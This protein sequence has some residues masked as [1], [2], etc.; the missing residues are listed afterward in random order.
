MDKMALDIKSYLREKAGLV[1]AFL[2]AYLEKPFEPPVLGESMRYSLLAGGKRLRPILAMASYEACG[3]NPEEITGCASSIE[4]IHT[5]SLIHDD[6]PAMD[7][8]DL[9][10]GRPT[11]H[12]VFGEAMAVLA[13]D[14]LLTE[15][16]LM[17]LDSG[18]SFAS[19]RLVEAVREISL[20][21][22]ARGMVGGQA[23]DIISENSEPS[24]ETLH[25][26]H[27]RKTGALI[28]ASARLGGIL[29][30]AGGTEMEALSG[31]GWSLGLAFQVVDDILDVEGD[32]ELLGKPTGSDEKRKK[33][34]YPALY[35]LEASWKKAGE[36]VAEAVD[37]LGPF[38]GN[39]WAL[40][41]IAGYVLERRH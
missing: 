4:L 38:G 8:D 9:R 16:F 41:G 18:A 40:R 37:S 11:N 32:P 21:A 22:G 13:G 25:F 28:A 1:N 14:G 26:I 12:K 33:M 36:L 10:R 15:A 31:Y 29:A 24:P 3:G 19:E 17:L 7:N 34:T 6:L 39:A 23:Q 27:R 5:Y 20:A 35:G 30:G 2:E